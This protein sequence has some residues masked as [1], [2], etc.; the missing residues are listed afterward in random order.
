ML[1]TFKRASVIYLS[2][3]IL[4]SLFPMSSFAQ[5]DGQKNNETSYYSKYF[6][7]SIEF[8]AKY[9]SNRK[10]ER[11]GSEVL[12]LEA[13]SYNSEYEVTIIK[14]P[15][16]YKQPDALAEAACSM[17][18]K[19]NKGKSE[20]MGK[21]TY[22][23]KN[24]VGQKVSFAVK[25]KKRKIYLHYFIIAHGKSTYQLNVYS[26]DRKLSRE[27]QSFVDSFELIDY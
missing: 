9:T 18:V 7:L 13:T 3:V 19:D 23:Y 17:L 24:S 10:T 27:S 12:R 6:N 2:A 5:A 26:L 21:G 22:N 11:D 25:D 15:K 1:H 4:V 8:P 16:L 14:T 20:V